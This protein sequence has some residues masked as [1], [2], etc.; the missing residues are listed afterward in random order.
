LVSVGCAEGSC[1]G[2]RPEEVSMRKTCATAHPLRVVVALAA[3][4]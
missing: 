2:S 4:A 3:P 1:P